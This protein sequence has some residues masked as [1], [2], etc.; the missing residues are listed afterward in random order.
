M[1][2]HLS[3]QRCS[4]WSWRWCGRRRRPRVEPS[5]SS[6]GRGR[7]AG[8]TLTSATTTRTT[9]W[10]P[11]PEVRLH[12]LHGFDSVCSPGVQAWD[13][14]LAVATLTLGRVSEFAITS[15][16]EEY[17]STRPW[18]RGW[19]A[20]DPALDFAISRREGTARKRR[21]LIHLKLNM[22]LFSTSLFQH[23]LSVTWK[24]IPHNWCWV[25]SFLRY[26]LQN[27]TMGR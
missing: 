19:G 11:P 26:L 6:T 10:T 14:S 2:F 15:R 3:C 16:R 12:H 17:S 23:F 20:G 18:R 5:L 27:V 21:K 9:A 13:P 4:S 25:D 7:E 24:K 22:L 1:Y 8:A